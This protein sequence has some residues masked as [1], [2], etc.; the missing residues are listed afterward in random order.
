MDINELIKE[1]I[2]LDYIVPD[3]IPDIELYMDQVTTFMDTHL[4]CSKRYADDKT[5]TKTMIN[6]YT[7]NNLMPPPTKKK[8]TKNHIYLL[9]YIYYFKNFLSISD[10][11]KLLAPMTNRFYESG[12]SDSPNFSS[13]YETLFQLEHD[14]Y[15]ELKDNVFQSLEASKAVF[16]EIENEEDRNFLQNFAFITLL[17]YDIYMKKQLVERMLDNL[18]SPAS[19]EK[20]KRDK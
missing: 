13:I 2:R 7:K 15:Y 18:Y 17:S 6:N 10:I 8:Y 11:Q 9:I 12:K 20:K 5:L 19:E 1:W 3:D 16:D 14:H 4:S